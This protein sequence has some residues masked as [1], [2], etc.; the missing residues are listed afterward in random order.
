MST[1]EKILLAKGR[2]A[3]RFVKPRRGTKRYF[4]CF[5]L[6]PTI[7]TYTINTYESG[8]K[9]RFTRY[10]GIQFLWWAVEVSVEYGEAK[11]RTEEYSGATSTVKEAFQNFAKA[12]AACGAEIKSDISH[13]IDHEREFINNLI[14]N[15]Q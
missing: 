13:R 7:L 6:I 4:E 8:K 3:V 10:T 5:Y 14:N 15:A 12:V 9:Y 2:T 1:T 11:S